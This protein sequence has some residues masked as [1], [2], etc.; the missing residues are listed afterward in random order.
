M[1]IPKT[2]STQSNAEMPSLDSLQETLISLLPQAIQELGNEIYDGEALNGIGQTLWRPLVAYV[3]KGWPGLDS[4]Q[5]AS[6]SLTVLLTKLPEY[7]PT[8]GKLATFA[9]GISRKVAAKEWE[10]KSRTVVVP[11]TKFEEE[12]RNNHHLKANPSKTTK[13][14]LLM[15]LLDLPE[16][17]RFLL[18]LLFIEERNASQ[19]AEILNL[20]PGYV[21]KKK[22]RLIARLEDHLPL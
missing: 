6:I 14:D 18:H 9:I 11:E 3:G 7:D 1:R 8:K 15:A 13:E 21:R 19:A 20:T 17:D 10:K 5:T 16:A 22:E 4:E 2:D 12:H